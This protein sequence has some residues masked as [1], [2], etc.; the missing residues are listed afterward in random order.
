MPLIS[1]DGETTPA[2]SALP[3]RLALAINHLKLGLVM[4][5]PE[6]RL[7]MHNRAIAEFYAAGHGVPETGMSLQALIERVAAAGNYPDRTPAE[8]LAAMLARFATDAPFSYQQTLALGRVVEAHWRKLPDGCWLGSY[9]DITQQ[10]RSAAQ[11]EY[12][13][14]HDK[15]TGLL[16]RP[17]VIAAL[18]QMTN[19]ARRGDGFAVLAV[20]LLRFKTVNE[21]QGH[22]A[23]DSMLRDVAG[24]LARSV[25]DSDVLARLANDEFAIIQAAGGQP[26]AADALARRIVASLRQ[27]FQVQGEEVQSGACVGIALGTAGAGDPEDLLRNATLALQ[28]AK[29]QST[30]QGG[31]GGHRFFEPEMDA[32]A[33]ARRALEADLRHALGRR[34]FELHYQPLVNV[35]RRRVSSFEAL[36]RWRH[37]LRGVVPPDAFIPL[38]EEIGMIV[39]IGEW[40]L[41]E[42]CSEAARWQGAEAGGL[43]VAVNLSA[44]QFMAPGLAD[45]VEQVLAETGLP[46]DR[47]ELEITETVLLQESE[48]TLATLHALRRLG[49]RISMDDFGTGYSSLSYLRSFPFD[50]IKIDKS[51]I[52]NVTVSEESKAIVRAIIGLGITLGIATVAEGVETMEQMQHLVA[53]GCTEV[54]GYFFSPPRPASEVPALINAVRSHQAA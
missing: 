29:A 48:A 41:R 33:R 46:G 3:E 39:P 50:K 1:G 2:M 21:T 7:V 22:A 8:V 43:R 53:D 24:R 9:H 42:A 37:P 11:L 36:L 18:A 44:A 23:G 34:E 13:E 5:D 31:R 14:R 54:Q 6:F 45:M 4:L 16:N 38:A 19:Q 10:H 51:F 28:L 25:R 30:R 47:L 49:A 20:N 35:A 26:E 15:L 17:A 27:P 12:M 52:S 40:V 32:R